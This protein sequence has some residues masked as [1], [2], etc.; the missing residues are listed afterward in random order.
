MYPFILIHHSPY[1]ITVIVNLMIKNQLLLFDI[2]TRLFA[3]I[4]DLLCN[5]SVHSGDQ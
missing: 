4:H 3:K 2:N 1:R 5:E